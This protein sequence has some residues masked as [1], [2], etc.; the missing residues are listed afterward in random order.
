MQKLP[1]KLAKSLENRKK[2]KAFRSLKRSSSLIDFSSN[3]YLGLAS[4]ENIYNKAHEI[5]K[6]NELLQNGATGSRLLSGNHILYDLTENYLAEF[7]QIEAALIYNSGYDANMGFFASVPK[8]GDLIF[9]DELVHA[10]I[11]DGIGMSHAKAYK[12]DHN[13]PESLQNK[14]SKI[15]RSE[16][17]EI[18]VVTESVF[19]MDGDMAPLEDFA[20]ISEAFG[21]FLIVDEAHA[22]GIFSDKGEGLVQ[23]L[24]IQDKVFAR[25][26]TFGKGPGCHGAVILGSKSLKDYLVNFSRSFIYTTALPPHSVATILAVYQ[27]FEKG[28]SLIQ[29]LK[30]NIQFFRSQ[31]SQNNL[32]ANFLDSNSAIQSCIIPGNE[33]VKNI[34]ESLKKKGFEVKPILSPTVPEGRE[35]LRFCLHSFNSE[36][37]ISRVLKIL[38]K[39]LA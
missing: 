12:F 3:D 34:A 24:E 10:S 37:D 14:L 33:Q 32:I 22:T 15:E 25:L 9:Y 18:Y 19:S 17:F 26:N 27:E 20:K 2:E 4:S 1:L 21:A 39:L 29:Q 16:D 6:E 13:S 35:R 31:V 5:L 36:E 28:I 8:R 38:A 7:H 11:R 30:N 23:E